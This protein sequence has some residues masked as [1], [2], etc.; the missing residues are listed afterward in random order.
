MA[1][2][3]YGA[4]KA[5]WHD[6]GRP[7]DRATTERQPSDR[8]P[9]ATPSGGSGGGGGGDAQIDSADMKMMPWPGTTRAARA[10]APE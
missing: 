2:G 3:R 7:S 9:R 4:I 10:S 8:Q 1:S 5:A 6:D